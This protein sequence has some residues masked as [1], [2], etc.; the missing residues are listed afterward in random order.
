MPLKPLDL[1][2]VLELATGP[3]AAKSY[4]E[5]A[6]AVGLSASEVHQAAT[7]AV[8][9]GLLRRGKSRTDK[10][11]PQIRAL[12]D[13]LEHG[14]RHAFFATPGRI[15]RGMP[16]AHSAPPLNALVLPGDE[17]P[18][19]WPAAD[20]AVRGRAVEPLYRSVP[21]IARLN[22]K[23]Y[24]VLALVDALRCGGAR[25]RKLAVQELEK[26]LVDEESA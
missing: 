9:A 26:R 10:P 18:L 20:G 15:V 23:L 2:V 21:T 14:V 5:L 8:S 12:L 17:L 4:A 22:Q 3:R 24:E 7:R 16:T 6:A 13:F 19:V 1:V 11:K 25:E